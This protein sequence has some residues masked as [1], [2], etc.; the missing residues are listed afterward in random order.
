MID[1]GPA[2]ACDEV[3]LNKMRRKTHA[4]FLLDLRLGAYEHPF[5][6][7]VRISDN[8]QADIIEHFSGQG[9]KL[10]VHA[11]YYIN[12][13]S[14]D[15]E[16]IQN[17]YKYLLD[18]VLKAR[19]L[20]ADRVVFHPGSLT[21]QTR[22][23]AMENCL[24]NLKEFIKIMDD[25]N[26]HD[27]YICPETMGK[28]GQIGTWQ[29]VKQMCALDE[30]IIPC[31]DFGH[32]NAF[33]LGGLTSEEKYHEILKSFIEE[34]NKKEIHI[35]FSRIEFTKKGEKKH[36]TLDEESEFGPNYQEMINAIEKYD[37][38]FR[39]IS[40]SNGTQTL[41]SKKMLEYYEKC[42]KNE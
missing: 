8:A 39:V 6:F 5:T 19:E 33:T 31:L 36:L 25:N 37:A 35:H 16:K 28:H 24:K 13:A 12:F 22:E 30:R 29:E 26:I 32:I 1:F 3:V 7:G 34:L 18:S 17:T 27:C 20:G 40:E 38:N 10:S 41:D 23:E 42:F 4:R 2:G 15:P 9:L 11:P 14:S 21:K